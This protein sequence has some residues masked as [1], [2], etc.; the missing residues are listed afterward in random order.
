MVDIGEREVCVLLLG[1]GKLELVV[2]EGESAALLPG[3][4]H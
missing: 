4:I 2:G 3:F 1:E